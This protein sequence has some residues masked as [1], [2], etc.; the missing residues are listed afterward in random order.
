MGLY[1]PMKLVVLIFVM[2]HYEWHFHMV[3]T[4]RLAEGIYYVRDALPVT[5]LKVVGR[6]SYTRTSYIVR[7]G[8]SIDEVYTPPLVVS[9]V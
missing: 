8:L 7:K 9:F 1:K 4:G 6:Q 2:A 5:L 3:S